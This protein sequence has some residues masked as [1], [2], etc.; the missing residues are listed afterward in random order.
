MP[1]WLGPP[2]LGNP[3]FDPRRDPGPEPRLP[4]LV[5]TAN[6]GVV[7]GGRVVLS[8]FLHPERRGEVRSRSPVMPRLAR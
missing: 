3:A 5:F 2:L 6:A 4:D 7:A 8:H 1:H